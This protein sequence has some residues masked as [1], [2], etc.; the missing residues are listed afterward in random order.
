MISK[1]EK[2]E[3][4]T[5]KREQNE[6]KHDDLAQWKEK[7]KIEAKEEHSQANNQSSSDREE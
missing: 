5:Q 1:E 4:I 3:V 2:E 6:V 7:K